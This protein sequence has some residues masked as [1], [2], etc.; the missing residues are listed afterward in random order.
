[1]SRVHVYYTSCFCELGLGCLF[2]VSCV[3]YAYCMCMI[4]G[5]SMCMIMG[6][7][8]Y[9]TWWMTVLSTSRTV[10]ERTTVKVDTVLTY[11]HASMNDNSLADY[12][13]YFQVICV[14]CVSF[15]QFMKKVTCIMRDLL[16][17]NP[18]HSLWNIGPSLHL[19]ICFGLGRCAWLHPRTFGWS[20]S[21]LHDVLGGENIHLQ[22]SSLS[23]LAGPH[24]MLFPGPFP[25]LWMD[26]Y[27]IFNTQVSL[28]RICNRK[29]NAIFWGQYHE[30]VMLGNSYHK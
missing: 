12:L 29:H 26:R 18:L 28:E 22:I 25:G 3:R 10:L 13:P 21:N 15:V 24:H 23:G 8:D 19:S 5:S 30:N 9:T 7:S 20:C 27:L 1:M 16:W 17:L 14:L 2:V 4:A 6:T 11:C